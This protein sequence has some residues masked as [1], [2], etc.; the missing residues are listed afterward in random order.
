METMPAA[1][2]A[3]ESARSRRHPYTLGLLGCLPDLDHP[4]AELATLKR[5]PAW[6]A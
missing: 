5:D 3:D 1:E 2:L 4:K 6:L